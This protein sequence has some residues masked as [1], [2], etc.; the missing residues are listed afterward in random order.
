[1]PWRPTTSWSSGVA[2][3]S[4]TVQATSRK[5]LPIASV[6]LMARNCTDGVWTV[7]VCIAP[8]EMVI[9]ETR[10]HVVDLAVHEY[11]RAARSTT[12]ST[13]CVRGHGRTSRGVDLEQ[14]V[15]AVG[16]LGV[17]L[18][19]DLRVRRVQFEVLASGAA[20]CF[21]VPGADARNRARVVPSRNSIGWST[22]SC[23][24][25]SSAGRRTQPGELVAK[26]RPDDSDE[27]E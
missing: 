17:H 6:R 23:S 25:P 11:G 2:C 20:V 1:M 9:D 27:R 15:G 21:L 12:W 5:N 4:G 24:S 14:F 26:L 8:G 22:G 10:P 18:H 16:V 13:G 7:N 3:S 19:G